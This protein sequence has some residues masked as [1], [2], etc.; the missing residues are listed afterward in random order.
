MDNLQSRDATADQV[1]SR[2]LTD[3]PRAIREAHL[4]GPERAVVIEYL[5]TAQARDRQGDNLAGAQ[6][7]VRTADTLPASNAVGQTLRRLAT[8]FI[9][10]GR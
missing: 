6:Y 1:R 4:S 2:L 5:E 10:P 9:H 3:L 8:S 7:L